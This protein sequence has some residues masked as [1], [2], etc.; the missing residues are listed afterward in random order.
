LERNLLRRVET[1][2]PI[3]DPQLAERVYRE[4]LLN[5]LADNQNAWQMGADGHYH[6]CT[7]GP[8]EA[9]FSAQLSLLEDLYV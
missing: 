3:L 1:A 5:Y 8:D 4:G 7:P 9:P 6:R 2:F